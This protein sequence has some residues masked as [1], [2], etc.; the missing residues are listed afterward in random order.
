[1]KADRQIKRLRSMRRRGQIPSQQALHRAYISAQCSRRTLAN[2]YYEAASVLALRDHTERAI[3]AY[4][5]AL[6]FNPGNIDAWYRLG[7]LFE[8][9]AQFQKSLV[10]FQH[11]LDAER[12]FPSHFYFRIARLLEQLGKENTALYFYIKALEADDVSPDIFFYL[13]RLLDSLGEVDIATEAL[14]T[15]GKIYPEKMD[16]VSF[17]MGVFLEKKGYFQEACRC[18]DE[19][20]QRDPYFVFWRLKRQMAYPL[21]MRDTEQIVSFHHRIE[22]TLTAF[23]QRLHHQPI[24]LTREQLFLMSTFQANLA[25][26]A[27][28]HVPTKKLRMLMAEMTTHLL[29]L[30]A[31]YQPISVPDD[32]PIHLGVILAS[33][34]IRMGYLYVGAMAEHLDPTRFKVTF[35]CT[36]KEIERLFDPQMPQHF[37]P[38]ATHL[39]YQ[40]LDPDVFVSRD[41]LRAAHLDVLFFTEPTWDFHQHMMALL[42]VAPVQLTSWMNPGTSGLPTMDYF[43]SCDAMEPEEGA[44][45]YVEQLIA[46]AE[47]PSYVPRFDF[48][49]P[50]DRDYFGLDASWHLYG[51]LQ[52]LLKFHPDFDALVEGVLRQ[53]PQGHLILLSAQNQKL[54]TAISERLQAKMPD[55]MPRIWFFPTLENQDFL[56]LLQLMDVVLDPLYYGGGTTTYQALACGASL[57]TLPTPRML[58]KITEAL[59]RTLGYEEAIVDTPSAY[60]QRAV[61]LAR[62]PRRRQEIKAMLQK[63]SHRIFENPAAV[64]QFEQVLKSICRP[65][66]PGGGSSI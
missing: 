17:F 63:R 41:Q 46:E 55:L 11:C 27:Y 57:V 50:V 10:A 51:C 8:Q 31:D 52:N 1:M 26:L 30:N 3:A 43:Y 7:Q 45:D 19:A 20:I 39:S 18:Y 56:R 28:H 23:V 61:E 53:D 38:S 9:D 33:K 32:A 4:E 24:R 47:F 40:Q 64:V 49:A 21:V 59:C 22:T 37:S 48:P 6:Y 62:D 58:G 65:H 34:S 60:I 13:A 29:H 66:S 12:V 25:Y 35:F 42:R 5:R 2:W 36:S 16:F 15:L 44:E 54:A 14:M